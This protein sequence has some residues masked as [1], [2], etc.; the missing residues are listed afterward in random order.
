LEISLWI[1]KKLRSKTINQSQKFIKAFNTPNNFTFHCSFI[2][3]F[4]SL[5]YYQL[6]PW[7]FSLLTVSRA[8]SVSNGLKSRPLTPPS[9][10][11]T[12]HNNSSTPFP[13]PISK[14]TTSNCTSRANSCPYPKPPKSS[15]SKNT[16]IACSFWWK[17]AIK[18]FRNC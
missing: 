7:A 2:K 12:S 9:S 8:A 17:K 1:K 15:A 4:S 5:P 10:K 18:L 14:S 16:P 6:S 3:S 13:S 11:I